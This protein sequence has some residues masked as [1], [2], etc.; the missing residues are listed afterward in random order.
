MPY[1]F[2]EKDEF[3][4]TSMPTM[5]HCYLYFYTNQWVLLLYRRFYQ[6][7]QASYL[8]FKIFVKVER[9]VLALFFSSPAVV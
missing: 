7:K 8:Y 2:G 1:S 6:I 3:I 5:E 9:K 4:F